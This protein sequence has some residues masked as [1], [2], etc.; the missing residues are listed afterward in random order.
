[1]SNDSTREAILGRIQ[2]LLNKTVEKGATEAEA[3]S[4]MAAAQRLMDQHNIQSAE[5]LIAGGKGIAYDQV[6]AKTHDTIYSHFSFAAPIVEQVFGIKVVFLK[7]PVRNARPI[8]RIVLFGD[9]AAIDSGR[10]GLD[11]LASVYLR[12][13]NRYRIA[14]QATARD[15]HSYYAGLGAGFLARVRAERERTIRE[16]PGA[17]NALVLV[18]SKLQEAFIEKYPDVKAKEI[19]IRSSE[20]FGAGVRDSKEINLARSLE[21]KSPR[22]LASSR[23]AIK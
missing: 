23:K 5:L 20:A 17:S 13:W 3:Q 19:Q 6:V 4:A 12:L 2:N 8:I 22:A 9:P 15:M 7:T 16:L 14:N 11:F 21:N 18:D 1:M 10:W